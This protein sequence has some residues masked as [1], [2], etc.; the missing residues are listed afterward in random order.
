MKSDLARNFSIPKGKINVVPHGEFSFYK[1]W[2]SGN[3]PLL[4]SDKGKKRL[5]FFGE[6]RRNKGLEYL[7]KAEPL[8]SSRYGNYTICIAGKFSK[9]PGNDIEHYRKMMVDTSRYEIINRYIAN[10]EVA[11]IFE[12]SDIVVLPYTSASQSGILALA[13]GFGKPVVATDTGSI[14][15]VLEHGGTGLL[16]PP[17]DA[18]ALA[19]AISELLIDGGRCTHYAENAAI[20][21]RKRLN[22]DIIGKQTVGIYRSILR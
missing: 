3:A 9:D 14:G 20:V 5:L 4:R 18:I 1:K 7:I 6:V 15:E 11:E 8:I 22:W 12:S 16:V 13:F 2:I 10:N 19:G 17:G 21:A